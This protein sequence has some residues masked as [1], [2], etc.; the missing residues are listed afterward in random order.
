MQETIAILFLLSLIL[1][2][3]CIIVIMYYIIRDIATNRLD[4][5]WNKTFNAW[6]KITVGSGI[7]LI[8]SWILGMVMYG[9]TITISI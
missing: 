3:I 1:L 5:I 8:V 6:V 2:S 4:V 7:M 9:G